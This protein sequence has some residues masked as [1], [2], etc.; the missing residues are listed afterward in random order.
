MEVARPSFSDQVFSG[1]CSR[2][3]ILNPKVFRTLPSRTVLKSKWKQVVAKSTGHEMPPR[4]EVSE[5]TK[6]WVHSDISLVVV[7]VRHWALKHAMFSATADHQ[8]LCEWCQVSEGA[9]KPELKGSSQRNPSSW[10]VWGVWCQAAKQREWYSYDYSKF[11]P[12]IV[13]QEAWFT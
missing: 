6:S 2:Y 5:R 10:I 13:R 11:E 12:H 9:Q 1:I 8:S 4:L 7:G 3:L